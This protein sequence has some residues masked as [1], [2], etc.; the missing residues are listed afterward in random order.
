MKWMKTVGEIVWIVCIDLLD[1]G[2]S[3][4]FSLYK[5]M[6]NICKAQWSEAQWKEVCLYIALSVWQFAVWKDHIKEDI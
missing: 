1:V 2:L 6:P 4:V 3:Q 5:K